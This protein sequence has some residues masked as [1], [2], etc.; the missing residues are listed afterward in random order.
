M[1]PNIIVD[2]VDYIVI[3]SPC[4]VL[5]GLAGIV[6]GVWEHIDDKKEKQQ[7]KVE[8]HKNDAEKLYYTKE[9][10]K[11]YFDILGKAKIASGEN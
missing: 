2:A 3:A 10:K 7:A 6:A 4:V 9:I 8:R 11:L 5:F 1:M